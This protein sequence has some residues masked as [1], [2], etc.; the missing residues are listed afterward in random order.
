MDLNSYIC[1]FKILPKGQ[2]EKGTHKISL[3]P[4]GGQV[5]PSARGGPVTWLGVP[6]CVRSGDAVRRSMA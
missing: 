1:K 4:R 5:R 6:E 2:I 3:S